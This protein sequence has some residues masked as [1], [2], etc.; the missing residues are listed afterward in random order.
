MHFTLGIKLEV[1]VNIFNRKRRLTTAI[2]RMI[3]CLSIHL[4]L[5]WHFTGY[6][7]GWLCHVKWACSQRIN[8]AAIIALVQRMHRA[9]FN[10]NSIYVGPMLVQC[11]LQVKTVFIICIDPMPKPIYWANKSMAGLGQCWFEKK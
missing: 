7:H 4:G 10:D 5:Y 8:L 6:T 2:M 3:L 11:T 1:P 9:N